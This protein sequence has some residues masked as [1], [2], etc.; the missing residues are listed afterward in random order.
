MN[1]Q[2]VTTNTTG[3]FDT[4]R[5]RYVGQE[6]PTPFAAAPGVGGRHLQKHNHKEQPRPD[7]GKKSTGLG[8]PFVRKV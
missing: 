7:T 3:V 5:A 6:C 8:L 2:R 4:R 1:N